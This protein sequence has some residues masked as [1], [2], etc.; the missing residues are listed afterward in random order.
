MET[1]GNVWVWSAFLALLV[2]ALAVDLLVLKTKGAKKVSFK[3]ALNWSIAWVALSLLFNLGLWY[4]LRQTL[5]VEVADEKALQFLTGY[6][7]E[8]SLAV[9]NIFVFL[10]I[11]TFFGVP[12]AYQRK[13]LI[14]GVIGAIILRTILILIGAWLIAQFHWIL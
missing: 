11:F 9:D 1:I 8:K 2:V 4:Y 13:V 14:I 5:P 3:E 7:I 10:M 6:L 12:L